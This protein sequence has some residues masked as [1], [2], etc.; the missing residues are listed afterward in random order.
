VA[1]TIAFIGV[2]TMGQSMARNLALKGYRVTGFDVN[3]AALEA[4]VE[5]GIEPAES[6]SAAGAAA[7]I[8]ITM[9]PS[10]PHEEAAVL[11][12]EGL[13]AGLRK[14]ATF[15]E[16]STIDPNVTRK[17]GQEAAARG[18]DMIDAPVSGSSIGAVE[19]TLTM[20]VG[21]EAAVVER[22]RPVLMA[23]GANV[24][25]VGPLGMGMTVK[26]VNNMLAGVGVAAVAEAV[27]IAQRAGLDPKAMFDVITKSSGDSWAFRNRIP[28]AGVASST[29][30]ADEEFQPGFM[31]MLMLKDLDLGASLARSLGAPSILATVAAQ[32]Y[33]SACAQGYDRLDF[34]AV[35]EAVRSLNGRDAS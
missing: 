35:F 10:S 27:N 13:F 21:G 24:V 3:P 33:A 29:V 2:G 26:L 22:C 25:H 17:I 18:I 9:L 7:D 5:F 11:S 28:L 12:P 6:A 1:D 16:M 4:A 31:N 14:G 15:I 8:A 34:S 23:M 30:P 20:M 19:A 32:Y